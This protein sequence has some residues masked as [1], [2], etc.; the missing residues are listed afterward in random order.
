V[1]VRAVVVQGVVVIEPIKGI[2]TLV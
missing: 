1:D 2:V